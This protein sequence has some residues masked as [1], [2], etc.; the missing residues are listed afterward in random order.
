MHSNRF[1]LLNDTI[2]QRAQTLIGFA[3]DGWEVLVRPNKRTNA[4][5]DRMWAMLEDIARQV[6]YHGERYCKED[7]KDI[8]T[9]TLR[10]EEIRTA[11]TLDGDR[12]VILGLQTRKLNKREFSNLFLII[13]KFA[14]EK[15]VIFKED[16]AVA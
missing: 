2:R 7:W 16:R 13:E 11:P 15:G 10:G 4:Q 3:P 9:A 8:F 12:M 6:V 5:N 1:V 14:A